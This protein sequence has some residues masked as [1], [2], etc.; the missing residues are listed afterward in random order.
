MSRKTITPLAAATANGAE[1]KAAE[2][3][4]S[5]YP[6]C[7]A[8][9]TLARLRSA[10]LARVCGLSEGRAALIASVSFARCQS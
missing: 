2:A 7:L 5:D 10:H 6:N 9:A 8:P 3:S 4:M 1:T